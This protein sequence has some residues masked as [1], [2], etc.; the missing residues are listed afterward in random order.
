MTDRCCVCCG[1]PLPANH[2]HRTCSM[3]YGDLD[4]GTDGY[5]RREMERDE[6][7]EQ[8]REAPHAD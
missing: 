8:E 3:C 2:P 5:Y 6:R 4:Y 1:L 7:R